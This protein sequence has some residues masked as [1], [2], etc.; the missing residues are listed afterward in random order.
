MLHAGALNGMSEFRL[1]GFLGYL[2]DVK[3]KL[4]ESTSSL[5][6]VGVCSPRSEYELILLHPSLIKA[7]FEADLAQLL[8]LSS[9]LPIFTLLPLKLIKHW[10]NFVLWLWPFDFTQFG[11][12]PDVK[13]S[14]DSLPGKKFDMSR[15]KYID[16]SIVINVFCFAHAWATS[17]CCS[18][19]SKPLFKPHCGDADVCPAAITNNNGASIAVTCTHCTGKDSLYAIVE[20][21]N[22]HA[23]AHTLRS[24]RRRKPCLHYKGMVYKEG[25]SR[26]RA[27]DGF[28]YAPLV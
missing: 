15:A 25:S 16:S 18:G 14:H 11:L 23:R 3:N 7:A 20:N 9:T 27:C 24:P 26:C 5:K 4:P 19:L 13:V 17:F 1:L 21:K 8:G 10:G 22:N 2:S 28:S 6:A 12:L